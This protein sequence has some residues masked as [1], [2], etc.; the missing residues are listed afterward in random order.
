MEHEHRK[1]AQRRIDPAIERRRGYQP[2]VR[3]FVPCHGLDN[4]PA[5]RPVSSA[6]RYPP[7][8]GARALGLFEVFKICPADLIHLHPPKSASF[9]TPRSGERE[10]RGGRRG[11][12][13]PAFAGMTSEEAVSVALVVRRMGRVAALLNI[14]AKDR[15]GVCS[16]PSAAFRVGLWNGV[17]EI[18]PPP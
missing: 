1:H 2:S 4:T 9:P 15:T 6:E 13:V 7:F 17:G 11:S 16:R 5:Q 8:S 14:S 3:V 12:W 10:A 18:L